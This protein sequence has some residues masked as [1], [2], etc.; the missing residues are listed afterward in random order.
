MNTWNIAFSSFF[1]FNI[2]QSI[3]PHHR[4]WFIL[5]F[6]L[7]HIVG[8]I[9]YEKYTLCKPTNIYLFSQV[10]RLVERINKS[11]TH[12]RGLYSSIFQAPLI[13]KVYATCKLIR[14][15]NRALSS[16]STFSCPSTSNPFFLIL[17]TKHS[18]FFPG[19]ASESD[20]QRWRVSKERK[21]PS[22]SQIGPD[23]LRHKVSTRQKLEKRLLNATMFLFPVFPSR[24]RLGQVFSRSD[25]HA[26]HGRK[27]RSSEYNYVIALVKISEKW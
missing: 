27:S 16:S 21:S 5:Q 14:I 6:S 3:D 19:V 25:A 13:G 9:N 17:A 11:I 1:L 20:L 12:I 7:S 8:K 22:L 26:K 23:A 10:F 15:F 4:N 18:K 2:V 24:Q